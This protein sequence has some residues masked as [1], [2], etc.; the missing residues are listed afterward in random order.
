MG[1]LSFFKNR[2]I[3]KPQALQAPAFKA[4]EANANAAQL[5]AELLQVEQ[6]K[7]DSSWYA[8]FYQFIQTAGFEAGE[9][10]IIT[11]AAG[12]SF[13]VLKTPEAGQ[14]FEAVCIRDSKDFLLDK[15]FGIAINPTDTHAEWLFSYGDIVNLHINDSFVTGTAAADVR[16][17]EMT[18]RVEV[19]KKGEDIM[20]AQ[21]SDKY[22]P[23]QA[24]AIIKKLL[25]QKGIRNPKTLLMCR[26][27]G[28]R[29]IEE[30][31]FNVYPGDFANTQQRDELMQVITWYLPSHYT[32]ISFREDTW[33]TKYFEPL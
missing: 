11:D 10:P 13:F 33:M 4:P 5:V 16:H 21:P 2:Q 9:P 27:T 6:V 15:G 17:I 18:K 32:A 14:P 19:V 20:L 8:A 26:K 30:L 1:L 29:M 23:V 31:A 12:H 22:L 3:V 25:Q 7:R 28:G 24:R